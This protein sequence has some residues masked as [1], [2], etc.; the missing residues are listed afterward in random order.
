MIFSETGKLLRQMFNQHSHEILVGVGIAS[1]VSASILSAKA[2]I[3]AVRK[4]DSINS[5]HKTKTEIIKETWKYYVPAAST[6]ILGSICLIGANKVYAGNVASLSAA[7]KITESAYTE[8][9]NKVKDV[10][11]D[12]KE[13]QIKESIADDHVKFHPIS[14]YEVFETGHGSTLCFDDLTGRYFKS[15]IEFIKKAINDANYQL[16]DCM[17]M[18]LNDLYYELGL[19]S[20]RLGE[21]LGWDVSYEGLIEP[22]YSST[23]TDRGEPCLVLSFMVYPRA[24]KSL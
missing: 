18:S 8:Y 11:G 17:F 14:N 15:D 23:L 1:S 5:A 12:K 19:P 22:I 24:R 21:D 20:V 2:T 7:Y 6:L 3:K 13:T 10:I 4:L 9:K 16:I